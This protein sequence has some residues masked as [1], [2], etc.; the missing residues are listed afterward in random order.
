MTMDLLRTISTVPGRALRLGRDTVSTAMSIGQDVVRRFTTPRT[1]D[2][3]P[4]PEQPRPVPIVPTAA[5]AG[6]IEPD[7]TPQPEF[8]PVHV[9]EEP[10]AVVY[11]S[12][13]E[14]AADAVGASLTVAEPWDGYRRMTVPDVVDRLVVADTATLAAVRLYEQEHRGRRGVLDAVEA[15]VARST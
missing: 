8:E 2:P 11:S 15:Q 5:P 4:A 3:R 9:A 6:T 10:P 13:D 12:A 14:G 7:R 1:E